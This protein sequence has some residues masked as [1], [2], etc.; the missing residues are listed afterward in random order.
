M[1][2]DGFWLLVVIGGFWLVVS[3]RWL[4]VVGMKFELLYPGD[5]Y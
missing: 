5:Y 2:C 3:G 1:V 4:V